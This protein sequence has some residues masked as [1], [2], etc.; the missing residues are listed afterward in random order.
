M[1]LILQAIKSLFRRT[2]SSIEQKINK[3]GHGSEKIF[4]SDT[5][6]NFVEKNIKEM[7]TAIYSDE[8]MNTVVPEIR[9]FKDKDD[10][11]QWGIYLTSSGQM[12]VMYP[13]EITN[14]DTSIECTFGLVGTLIFP[15][16]LMVRKEIASGSTA[17]FDRLL[18]GERI[19]NYRMILININ[20]VIPA[21][22]SKNSDGMH[23]LTGLYVNES[24]ELYKIE[25]VQEG[26]RLDTGF[27]PY[28]VYATR[29]L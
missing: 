2:E 20:V 11:S 26:E 29:L 14:M 4:C 18:A 9:I 1:N 3:N 13:S 22:H 27:I 16:E 6:G 17:C 21:S 24:N 10:A 28:V 5:N 19:S 7:A 12:E 15:S 25:Y 23:V 8:G